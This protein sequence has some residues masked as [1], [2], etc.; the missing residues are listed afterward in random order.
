MTA[1]VLLLGCL[2]AQL[3]PSHAYRTD[4]WKDNNY[5]RNS[6]FQQKQMILA[7][8]GANNMHW[9]IKW[10]HIIVTSYCPLFLGRSLKYPNDINVYLYK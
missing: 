4:T 6:V 2:H 7:I 10:N 8:S 3:W 1:Q 9:D 5:V